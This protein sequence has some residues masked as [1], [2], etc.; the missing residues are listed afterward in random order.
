MR[1]PNWPIYGEREIE[2]LRGVLESGRWG[3]FN[4]IVGRFEQSFAAFQQC[5]Y[6]IS[7]VNGTATLETALTVCGIGPGDEVIVPAISFISSATA[8]SRVGALP[9]FVDIEPFTFNMDPARAAA[10]ITPRTKAIMVVHFGGLM[11]DMD[12]FTR[13]AAERNLILIE[14]AAHAHGSEWNGK[15]AGSLGL[16]GSFSFQ[17]S[18]VMTSGEGGMLTTNDAGFAARARAFV[19][20]GRREGQGWFFHYTLGTNFRMAAFEAAVLTAQLERLPGQIATATRNARLLRSE[21]AGVAGLRFQDEPAQA[22]AHSGYLLLG[23]I[24]AAKFGMSRDDFHAAVTAAGIPCTPFY[25]HPLYGNPMYQAGGCRVESCPVS[26]A[27]I[28]D[29]F[30]FPHR[31]L[32]AEEETIREIAAVIRY[33]AFGRES[34]GTRPLAR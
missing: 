24:D 2:L 15:R 27:S 33:L 21:L 20:Q 17:N 10:A 5:A 11:A 22:A 23:R 3:G 4:E 6:G 28:G 29:A 7:A 30:W 25:P 9:V 8:V 19:N 1:I 14:D 18:K 32:L 16:A 26:E 31:V 13:L 12:R 34:G